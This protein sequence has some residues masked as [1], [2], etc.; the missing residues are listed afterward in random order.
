MFRNKKRKYD[1][2]WCRLL[3]RLRISAPHRPPRPPRQERRICVRITPAATTLPLHTKE[4]PDAAEDDEGLDHDDNSERGE[5][6]ATFLLV[7]AGGL[8]RTYPAERERAAG[9]VRSFGPGLK[10]LE[11]FRID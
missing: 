8:E 7:G 4:P 2:R 9:L 6:R 11:M 1:A 10:Q 3:S 5:G